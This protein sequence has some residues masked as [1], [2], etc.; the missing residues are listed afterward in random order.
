MIRAGGVAALAALCLLSVGAGEADACGVTPRDAAVRYYRSL[1]QRA[2][3]AAWRCLSTATRRQFGGFEAWKSGYRHTAWT[4][5]GA[6]VTTD[7]AAGLA[8]IRVRVRSCTQRRSAAVQ[9]FRGAWEAL[10]GF[11]GWRLHEPHLRRVAQE[12]RNHC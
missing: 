10:D 5:L 11:A 4:R 9:R 8:T 3:P 12:S 6:A 1:D 2:F 7:Q